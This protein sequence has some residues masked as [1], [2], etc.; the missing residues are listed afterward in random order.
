MM[1]CLFLF[2]FVAESVP[3]VG[4]E[5]TKGAKGP[6]GCGDLREVAEIWAR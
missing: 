5:G 4:E 2:V 6:F 1:T 3:C